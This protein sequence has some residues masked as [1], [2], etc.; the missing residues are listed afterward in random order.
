[1]HLSAGG[2]SRTHR[3]SA[4]TES[5][6]FCSFQEFMGAGTACPV[7]APL[8][9]SVIPSGAQAFPAWFGGNVDWPLVFPF[10]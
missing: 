6:F 1:M 10:T 8:R 7:Q 5:P 9:R 2:V 4:G 3:L